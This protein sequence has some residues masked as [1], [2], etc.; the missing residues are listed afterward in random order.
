MVNRDGKGCRTIFEQNEV[1]AFIDLVRQDL[2]YRSNNTKCFISLSPFDDF[3]DPDLARWRD[4]ACSKNANSTHVWRNPG[5][6]ICRDMCCPG[7]LDD[8][9]DRRHRIMRN[10]A[11]NTP[12]SVVKDKVSGGVG[13]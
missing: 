1:D 6:T 11:F 3:T 7:N 5:M 2:D 8:L 12:C 13:L 9:P 10:P 4:C